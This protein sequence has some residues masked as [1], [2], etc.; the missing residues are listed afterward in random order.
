MYYFTTGGDSPPKL[1]TNLLTLLFYQLNTKLPPALPWTVFHTIK[2][3][4]TLQPMNT[5]L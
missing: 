3:K 4:Q 2:H 1:N 5:K